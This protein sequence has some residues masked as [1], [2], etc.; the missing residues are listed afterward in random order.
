MLDKNHTQY[1]CLCTPQIHDSPFQISYSCRVSLTGC[2]WSKAWMA[3]CYRWCSHLCWA[4]GPHYLQDTFQ[5]MHSINRV[6]SE[7]CSCG[8][9]ESRKS[10]DSLEIYQGPLKEKINNGGH[11]TPKSS[12]R[13]TIK[14]LHSLLPEMKCWVCEA[15]LLAHKS[16][17]ALVKV[18]HKPRSLPKQT[19]PWNILSTQWETSTQ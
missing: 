14:V 1:P 5:C 15:H 13:N 16:K 7:L 11:I 4:D 8:T 6:V 17:E 18:S 9:Q 10:C 19:C 3:F 2:F 12:S